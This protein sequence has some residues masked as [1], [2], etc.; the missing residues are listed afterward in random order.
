MNAIKK[1][2]VLILAFLFIIPAVFAQ[3]DYISAKE[4]MAKLK[5]DK[6]MVT[7]HAGGAKDYQKTHIRGSILFNYKDT[8]K[9]G[10]VKGLMKDANDLAT[11][12]GKAGVSNNNTIVVYD[13][14]TQKYSGRI[15]WLLKYLGASDVKLLHKDL[16]T[17]RKSRVPLTAA[18]AKPKATTFEVH[19]N[20][21][22]LAT[23]SLVKKAIANPQIVLIDARDTNE[24]DGTDGKSKGHIESA[25]HLNYKDLVTPSGAF[26]SKEEIKALAD[27]AGITAD[28][29]LVLYC[30]T[31]I[32]GA[33]SFFAFRNILGLEN[34]KLYDGAIEEWQTT[35]A[36]TK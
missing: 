33:V 29:E 30:Q 10:D 27:K 31:S 18:P 5:T 28:K 11:L 25:I 3:A 36:L 12:L 19:I 17:W 35:N 4:Y 8:E 7:L 26:K 20:S 14:G 16:N 24:F 6:N 21:N 34:V 15:Y 22:I 13:G 1:L 2:S 9:P 32:R 23:T